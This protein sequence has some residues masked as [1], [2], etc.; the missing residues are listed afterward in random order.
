MKLLI[1]TQKVNKSDQILG[2]FHRWIEEFAKNVES[3]IVICLEEGVHD[4]PKNVKV[5]SLGKE[6]G[7]GKIKRLLN[8]YKYIWVYRKEYDAVFVHMNQIYI[9]LG[10][11]L[12]RIL[13][14][15]MSLWY[16]H[17]KV[18]FSLR[19]AEKIVNLVFT[20]TQSGFNIN[21][22]KTKIVGQG[23]DTELFKPAFNNKNNNQIITVGRVAEVKNIAEIIDIITELKDYNLDIV[24]AP[25]RNQDFDY[26]KKLYVDVQKNNLASRVVFSGP[27]KQEELPKKYN[28]SHIFINLSRTGSLDKAILEA[29]SCGLQV[30]TTNIAAK[31]LEGIK[32]ISSFNIRKDTQVISEEIKNMSSLG[33]NEKAREFVVKNHSINSLIPKIINLIQK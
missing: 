10:G 14:K 28:E 12:W 6:I 26:A 3:L 9:I 15:K 18:S 33:L 23:I 29:M 32:F 27:L 31:N 19:V 7:A 22:I 4:L 24:G 8:F 17:G 20:S 21:T 1:I 5:L 16:A 13:K 30:V 2:F 11:L 25:I